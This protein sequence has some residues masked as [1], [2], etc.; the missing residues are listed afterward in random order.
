MKFAEAST[1]A[2]FPDMLR[3]DYTDVLLSSY[4]A[5]AKTLE[6]LCYRVDSSKRTET[7]RKWKPLGPTTQKLPENSEYP[8][9]MMGAETSVSITNDKYGDVISWTREMSLFNESADFVRMAAEQGEALAQGLE[10]NIATAIETSG[11]YTAYGSTITLTAG[12][13]ELAI[14]KFNTQTT[15]DAEGATVK[16]GLRADTLLV[17]PD[18]EMSAKR[19]LQSAQIPGSA[20]NDINVLQGGLNVV[21]APYLTSTSVWYLLKAKSPAGLIMQS[22]IGPPPETFIQDVKSSQ[23]SDSTFF[24]DRINYRADMLYGIDVYDAKLILKSASS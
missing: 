5:V 11:N 13:L 1:S 8:S 19:L 3:E 14:I 9:R 16:L 7:Y 10:K 18:L 4:G 6:P 22:V 15:T 20:N 12:N 24:F 17:P 21:V 23:L 2:E